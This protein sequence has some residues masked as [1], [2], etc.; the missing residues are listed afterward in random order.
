MSRLSDC[1]LWPCPATMGTHSCWI[2]EC[3]IM[4]AM[5]FTQPLKALPVSTWALERKF[6]VHGISESI[7]RSNLTNRGHQWVGLWR[8]YSANRRHYRH[9]RIHRNMTALVPFKKCCIQDFWENITK[10]ESL[11]LLIMTLRRKQR[12]WEVTAKLLLGSWGP[13]LGFACLEQR[14]GSEQELQMGI[15]C[16]ANGSGKILLGDLTGY[17]WNALGFHFWKKYHHTE[18]LHVIFKA[19]YLN[20]GGIKFK[21]HLLSKRCILMITLEVNTVFIY[22]V[23]RVPKMVRLGFSL[24]ANE[25]E[26]SL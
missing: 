16:L 1:P 11:V 2:H 17:S 6:P 5:W 9:C 3:C 24:F 26:H 12:S 21:H 20:L 7:P 19:T 18:H 14:S 13:E 8:E 4:H 25:S 23:V 10:R 22:C 15:I